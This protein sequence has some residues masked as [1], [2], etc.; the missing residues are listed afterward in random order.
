MTAGHTTSETERVLE[1]LKR[2]GHN[3]TSFQILEPELHYWFDGPDACVAYAD[4]GGAWIVAGGPVAAR[5]RQVEVM[6]RFMRAAKDS[7]KRVRFFALERDW[8]EDADLAMLHLGEQPVWDPAEWDA[9]VA[10]KR[11]LREQL[12]RARAKHVAVR[13]VSTDELANPN[14]PT[15]LAIDHMIARWLD[16]QKMA[17]MGF[18]VYLDPYH[19]PAERRFFVAERDGGVIGI[20]VAVPIYNRGGW[21]FEDVLRDPSAPNGTIELLFDHAMRVVR[22]EGSGHVTFGLAPLAG[23]THRGMRT[24]RDHTRWLYD[25]EGLRSFKAKL[26]PTSWQPVYLGY[27]ARERGVRAV[28]DTLVAF[29]RGSFVRFGWRTLVHRAAAV[30]FLL[31][32]MLG[33]WAGVLALAQTERWFP[34]IEV[35][36]AWV[37]LDLVLFVLLLVLSV[38]W[39]RWLAMALSAAA[40]GDFTLGLTQVAVHNVPCGVD[41]VECIGIAL[42]LGAP[43]FTAA[44]LWGARNRRALYDSWARPA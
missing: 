26:M 38:R 39:N 37:A 11:S 7:R 6:R 27:P 42:A 41:L 44:F 18:V 4:T 14:D 1:I 34:S 16:A 40:F 15:R 43:L 8:S 24:I 17:P 21:F 30:T 5:D 31:A 33:A 13:Q 35:H 19:L 25:F 22:D 29:A 32:L 28:I 23:I 20:L 10:S 3:T 12:R 36:H 2:H 9:A